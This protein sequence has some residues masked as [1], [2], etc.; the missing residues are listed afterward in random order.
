MP[1]IKTNALLPKGD[2]NGLNAIAAQLVAEAQR[3]APRRL[4]AALILFDGRR[5]SVDTDTGE[6]T[7]TLRV[8]RAELILSDDMPAA[9]KLI[10]RSSEDRLG[11]TVL[12]LDLEK[13]I[14]TAFKELNLDQ[15]D[16]DE[17]AAM[18]AELEQMTIDPDAPI[19]LMPG[20]DPDDADPEAEGDRDGDDDQDDDGAW[21]DEEDDDDDD[22]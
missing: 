18:D 5:A 14:E 2:V 7:V 6:W 20:E 13:E 17:D 21:D 11:A 12:P 8:R 22:R 16:P 9:E 15:P 3:K 1:E 10:R 19:D 4:R